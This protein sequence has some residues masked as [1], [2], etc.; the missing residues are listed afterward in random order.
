MWKLKRTH[1]CGALRASDEGKT[2]VLNGWVD[3]RRNFGNLI[4]IDLRDRFGKT[5]VLFSPD[6]VPHLVAEADK[7]KAEFVVAVK[8][9]VHKRDPKAFNAK[10]PTGEI[11]IDVQELEILNEA[12]TPPFPIN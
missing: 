5:Q 11:E 6:R 3:G 8:G 10:I 4:F 1:T 9:V 7:L 12:K 2:V